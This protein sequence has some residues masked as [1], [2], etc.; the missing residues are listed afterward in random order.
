[1]TS[2]FQKLHDSNNAI[3]HPE[4]ASLMNNETLPSNVYEAVDS[5]NEFV[6]VDTENNKS[7]VDTKQFKPQVLSASI[8]C[9][10]TNMPAKFLLKVIELYHLDQ[11][12]DLEDTIKELKAEAETQAA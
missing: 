11:C 5:I 6:L 1:M 4:L 9:I 8:H 7:H 12:F 10:R 2:D 3:I